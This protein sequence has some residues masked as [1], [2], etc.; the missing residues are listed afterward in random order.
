MEVETLE[1]IST[2]KIRQCL[3]NGDCLLKESYRSPGVHFSKAEIMKHKKR[4][5][6]IL[7]PTSGSLDETTGSSTSSF[8]SKTFLNSTPLLHNKEGREQLA[9]GLS[10]RKENREAN[11][12][13]EQELR[14]NQLEHA[15]NVDNSLHPI[16]QKWVSEDLRAR[17][18]TNADKRYSTSKTPQERVVGMILEQKEVCLDDLVRPSKNT[19]FDDGLMTLVLN[20][21][22]LESLTNSRANFDSQGHL[23]SISALPIYFQLRLDLGWRLLSVSDVKGRNKMHVSSLLYSYNKNDHGTLYA[24]LKARCKDFSN[25]GLTLEHEYVDVVFM[26]SSLPFVQRGF[27]RSINT[28]SPT[29]SISVSDEVQDYI[30]ELFNGNSTMNSTQM[31]VKLIEK[32]S[33]ARDQIPESTIA[34]M[35]KKFSQARKKNTD[36]GNLTSIITQC[37]SLLEENPSL[38][39]DFNKTALKKLTK[40]KIRAYLYHRGISF[41][42]SNAKD[43]LVNLRFPSASSDLSGTDIVKT[44]VLG[45]SNI[46]TNPSMNNVDVNFLQPNILNDITRLPPVNTIKKSSGH[47]QHLAISQK[48]SERKRSLTS[49][50]PP[51][52]AIHN[53]SPSSTPAHNKSEGASSI[54]SVSFI[55]LNAVYSK[56]NYVN[57][58][59]DCEDTS[60]FVNSG[61]EVKITSGVVNSHSASAHSHHSGTR[62][63][64]LRRVPLVTQLRLRR[65]LDP[66]LVGM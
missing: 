29:G 50:L 64:R 38:K 39:E 24:F 31:R 22:L 25:K 58:N 6:D 49:S 45:N 60:M 28:V 16:N 23:V 27:C 43:D 62:N 37:K 32:F 65:L 34:N 19:Q 61:K 17:A 13:V 12:R 21:V 5:D 56:D 18:T 35:I 55:G 26:K 42:E 10:A 52:N 11:R 53:S 1:G 48:P 3:P 51:H 44:R 14:N 4:T 30:L 9:A 36:H 20:K 33:L 40:D 2:L 57:S 47:P 15:H 59:L 7:F 66:P 63:V 8:P 54:P 46:Y 41:T